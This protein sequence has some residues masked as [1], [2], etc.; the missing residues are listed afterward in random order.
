M[1]FLVRTAMRKHEWLL[2]I[3]I[4]LIQ[5]C[6]ISVASSASSSAYEWTTFHHDPSRSGYTTDSMPESSAKL[7]WN[8]TTME[9]VVS[10]PA[11]ANGAAFLGCKDGAV[12]CLNASNGELLWYF[13]SN[14]SEINSSPAIYNNSVYVG[15]DGG[16]VYCLDFAT[17]KPLW[18]VTIGGFVR[19]SPAV[20]DGRVYREPTV[21]H[22]HR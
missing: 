21:A 22:P 14:V 9:A 12:Y 5:S 11:I 7:L 4:L 13:Y 18:T 6:C 16:D 17:G 2:I 20:V 8:F 10:S 3:L 15:S 19:S 1:C